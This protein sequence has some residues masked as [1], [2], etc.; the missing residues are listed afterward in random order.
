MLLNSLKWFMLIISSVRLLLYCCVCIYLKLS[1][2]WKLCWLVRFDSMLIEV[3]IVSL[4]LFV[5]SFCLCWLSCVVIV[6]KVCVSGMNL[7][8]RLLWVVC[9]VRLF[10]L[11]CLVVLV[12]ILIG[13]M[14]SFLV[15]ISVLSRMNMMIKLS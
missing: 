7:V 6:L 5:I 1:W 12:S 13:L 8:G 15:V 9:V 10:L 11:I 2:F 14:M 3:I 4:L